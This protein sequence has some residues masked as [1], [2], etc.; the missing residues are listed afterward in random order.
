MGVC[1]LFNVVLKVCENCK[2][3]KT[4]NNFKN[5]DSRDCYACRTLKRYEK[6]K[7]Y[8]NTDLGV[9]ALDKTLESFTMFNR[10]LNYKTSISY[11]EAVKLVSQGLANVYAPD[12]IYY[13]KNKRIIPSVN[14]AIPIVD[15]SNKI[16]M[17]FE[18]PSFDL[19]SIVND[20]YNINVYGDCSVYKNE[21]VGIAY[22]A[23]GQKRATLHSKYCGKFDAGSDTTFSE[24]LCIELIL[25]YV[26]RLDYSRS[27][28][29]S[30]TI[31][32][33]TDNLSSYQEILKNRS[34]SKYREIVRKIVYLK[35]RILE[36]KYH[37]KVNI[38]YIKDANGNE[39]HKI[40]HKEARKI[41]RIE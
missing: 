40:V 2:E 28:H 27:L 37:A 30:Y 13:H 7:Q 18:N 9:E 16:V 29:N 24:L 10:K 14:F 5:E 38:N 23:L 41:A 6:I 4:M 8:M 3:A 35:E 1:D 33:Y 20:D 11:D 31:N 25:K 34:N 22:L 21:D 17:A 26:T 12:T 39:F 36:K 15:L 32:V 19:I